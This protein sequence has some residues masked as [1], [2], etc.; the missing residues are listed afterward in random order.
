MHARIARLG[1]DELTGLIEGIEACG[2]VP[3]DELNRIASL[4]DDDYHLARHAY[5]LAAGF[6]RRAAEQQQEEAA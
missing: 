5:H 1:W 3:A 4:P 6:A 2:Q